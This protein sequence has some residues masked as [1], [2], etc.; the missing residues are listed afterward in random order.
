MNYIENTLK[1]QEDFSEESWNELLAELGIGVE[2]QDKHSPRFDPATGKYD[3]FGKQPEPRYRLNMCGHCKFGAT[4]CKKEGYRLKSIEAEARTASVIAFP[5]SAR[6]T[7]TP[8][9]ESPTASVSDSAVVTV[10]TGNVSPQL[11]T[12]I[13]AGLQSMNTKEATAHL[14]QIAQEIRGTAKTEY[15]ERL[16]AQFVAASIELCDRGVMPAFRDVYHGRFIKS[17][18]A[19][20]HDATLSHDLRFIDLCWIAKH[21]AAGRGKHFAKLLTDDG[22][23]DHGKAWEFASTRGSHEKK[24]NDLILTPQIQAEL[25]MIKTDAAKQKWYRLNLDRGEATTTIATAIV[26]KANDPEQLWK[27]YALS[28]MNGWNNKGAILG[29]ASRLFGQTVTTARLR[30]DIAWLAGCFGIE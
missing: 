30:K 13:R 29:S 6:A 23:L 16:R 11:L 8:T 22:Y 26:R 4:D 19:S 7:P 27:L 2:K 15:D 20:E 17:R 3:C 21:H 1:N 9:V 25:F 28:E 12:G 5:K 14:E 10:T 24:S 18:P